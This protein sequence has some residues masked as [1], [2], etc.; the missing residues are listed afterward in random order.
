MKNWIENGIKSELAQ[1]VVAPKDLTMRYD[2]FDVAS[3]GL[4]RKGKAF[5]TY[6][7]FETL[8][9]QN[10]VP[11]GCRLPTIDEARKLIE[12]FANG[13]M[14]S[15]KL[16]D[17][18]HLN[19]GGYVYPR[20]RDYNRNPNELSEAIENRLLEGRYWVENPHDGSLYALWV[21]RHKRPVLQTFCPDSGAKIRLVHSI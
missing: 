6:E 12:E 5:F 10:H 18:L 20:M 11:K 14:T 19:Y 13:E 17:A 16:V 15:R 21:H 8:Q 7:E 3:G 1:I 4:L 9:K 2:V